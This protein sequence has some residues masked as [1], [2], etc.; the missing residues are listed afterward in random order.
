[1]ETQT[2][3]VSSFQNVSGNTTRLHFTTL[4]PFSAVDTVQVDLAGDSGLEWDF[5]GYNGTSGYGVNSVVIDRC[6]YES[7]TEIDISSES[8]LASAVTWELWIRYA[9]NSSISP[10]AITSATVTLTAQDSG[11]YVGENG[12]DNEFFLPDAPY[13]EK[14]YPVSIWQCDFAVDGGFAH[15]PLFP[16]AVRVEP[17]PVKQMPYISVYDAHT[18]QAQ[19]EMI[20]NNGL[21]ILTPTVC[22]DHE[23]LCGMWS[24]NLE[25]PIDPERRC[26]FLLVGNL[27]RAG[28]QLFTIKKTDEAWNGNSGKISVYAEMIWYQLADEWLLYTPANSLLIAAKKG[29]TAGGTG[30]IDRIMQLRS[31]L[32]LIPNGVRYSFSWDSDMT[33]D[34]VWYALLDDGHT[35]IDMIIGEGGLI[36]SKGGELHRDNFYFSVNS[37]KETA[38]NNAFDICV[39]KNLRGI[40]RTVDTTTMCTVYQLTDSDTGESLRI[41]WDTQAAFADVWNLFLPHHVVRS[42]L[43]SY[44]PDTEHRFDLLCQEAQ[45]RF[46]ANCMPVIC[47]EIDM[48]DVRQNPDF[49]MIAEESLRCGDI[50][51]VCD[52]RLNS[53]PVTLEITETT[54]DR[55]TDK[56]KS[57][58][59]G[60]KQ[61]FVYHPNHPV[62]WS[63][64]GEP[65]APSVLEYE[66]W[67]KDSTG[68]HIYD[69]TGRKWILKKGEDQNAE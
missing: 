13:L 49:S 15:V 58:T 22:D 37:R 61:S 1:M 46:A 17:Y 6:W 47:Y 34:G 67:V 57:F 29:H 54:Y 12:I 60:Q 56:I 53:E 68:R 5:V 36:A 69:A 14:P 9:D 30:A 42:E 64:N 65:I 35:P 50:G 33:Y 66:I 40:R 23:E 43:I 11:W 18:Q 20:T 62:I 32:V 45:A 8:G 27:I 44:P 25:H 38:R 26:D 24:L 52:V 7:G 31:G 48:E 4:Q 21:A 39:G 28:G 2:I 51:R 3:T 16:D 10:S 19:L 55:I 59:V 63:D 41:G